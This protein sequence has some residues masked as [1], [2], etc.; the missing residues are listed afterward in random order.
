[1]DEE[2]NSETYYSPETPLTVVLT[3]LAAITGYDLRWRQKQGQWSLVVIDNRKMIVIST[4]D[5]GEG[6]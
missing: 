1:M 4:H 6:E 5:L 3:V 2:R